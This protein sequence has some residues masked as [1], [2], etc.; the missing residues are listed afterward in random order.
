[1]NSFLTV[2]SQLLMAHAYVL[3]H[4][5]FL[6]DLLLA[7]KQPKLTAEYGKMVEIACLGLRVPMPLGPPQ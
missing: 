5:V 1:M 3:F 7:R 4:P 6:Q 2:I